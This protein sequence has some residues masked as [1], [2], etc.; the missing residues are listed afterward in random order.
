M[1]Q[2]IAWDPGFQRG[3]FLL[4]GVTGALLGDMRCSQDDR[5]PQRIQPII[6]GRQV[7]GS[8]IVVVD[9]NKARLSR[10]P[11]P[12]TDGFL[13]A[14][15]SVA[16]GVCVAECAPVFLAVPRKGWVGILHAGWR[17][18]AA[19][20]VK[21]ACRSLKRRMGTTNLKDLK[22]SIGPHIGPCCYEV[23]WGVA[24][25]FKRSAA[26]KADRSSWVLN[27]GKEIAIQLEECG[28][29]PASISE[30]NFCTVHDPGFFSHRRDGDRRRMLAYIVRK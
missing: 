24:Q 12:E 7:H 18:L 9:G 4:H 3:G 19:G 8:R 28:I 16:L 15:R 10:L 5:C 6:L 2:G 1:S 20:I 13:T 14:S 22:V 30:A 26:L 29:N 25:F 11:V 27:L 21:K 23:Q 17:G